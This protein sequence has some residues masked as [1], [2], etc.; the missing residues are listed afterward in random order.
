MLPTTDGWEHVK[1]IYTMTTF[2]FAKPVDSRY[3]II[4][5]IV[6]NS[7]KFELY[8]FCNLPV[9]KIVMLNKWQ[10]RQGLLKLANML[11]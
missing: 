6:C 1:Y 7:S 2:T 10:F 3:A 11:N 5:L 4:L 9:G 8:I